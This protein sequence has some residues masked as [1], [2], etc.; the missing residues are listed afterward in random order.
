VGRLEHVEIVRMV[1]PTSLDG[2]VLT[3]RQNELYAFSCT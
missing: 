2:E 3:V 1:G